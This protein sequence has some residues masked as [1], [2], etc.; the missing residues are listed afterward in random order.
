VAATAVTA[1]ANANANKTSNMVCSRSY[2][3]IR[4]NRMVRKKWYL[5]WDDAGLPACRRTLTGAQRCHL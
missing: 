1:A 4:V 5:S 2:T 3:T